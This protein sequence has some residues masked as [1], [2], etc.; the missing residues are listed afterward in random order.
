MPDEQRTIRTRDAT[1]YETG[2]TPAEQLPVVE[3]DRPEQTVDL[4]Q[5]ITALRAVQ[6][7]P[8]SRPSDQPPPEET[9]ELTQ[10]QI[11]EIRN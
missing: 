11:Q 5:A 1:F 9:V 3:F 4:V 6:S 10:S 2:K 7:N 8:G